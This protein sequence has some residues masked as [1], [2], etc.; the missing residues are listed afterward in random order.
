MLSF[1]QYNVNSSSPSN[2]FH[3][4]ILLKGNR[5]KLDGQ[6][7]ISIKNAQNQNSQK[8]LVELP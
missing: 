2:W 4:K 3:I 6:L 1:K 7:M 5:A 8:L